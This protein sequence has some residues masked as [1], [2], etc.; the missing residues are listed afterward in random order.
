MV[1]KIQDSKIK[2]NIIKEY[3]NGIKN[4]RGTGRFDAYKPW[5]EAKDVKSKAVKSIFYSEKFKRII[6]L[7]SHGEYA[8]FLQLE[9]NDNVI[10]VREQYPLD[11]YITLDICEQLNI[12]HPGFTIGGK[13][14]TTDFLITYKGT[15][16][17]DHAYSALQV[18]YDYDDLE[19]PRTYSKLEIEKMYWIRKN[20]PWK[21]VLSKKFNNILDKNLNFLFPLRNHNFQHEF[22]ASL[23]HEVKK[24]MSNT[25]SRLIASYSNKILNLKI[26]NHNINITDAINILCAKKILIFDIKNIVF[27]HCKIMDLR[28]KDDD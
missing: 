6:H 4:G 17:E 3:E 21:I 2:E 18:K 11:P 19:N 8:I 9:W 22:I 15:N 25:N 20:I 26:G 5:L 12:L 14:M 7:F 23:I 13:V 1:S 24:I 27:K 16:I 10:E 28:F